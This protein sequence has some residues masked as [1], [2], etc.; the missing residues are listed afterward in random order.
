MR[1]MVSSGNLEKILAG[2]AEAS[3]LLVKN[4][5]LDESLRHLVSIMG[6]AVEADRCYV[7]KNSLLNG[8]MLMDQ[9]AEWTADG[10]SVQLHNP[11]LQQVSYNIYPEL[12]GLLEMGQAVT[13]LVADAPQPFRGL[14]QEQDILSYLFL[15]IRA[16]GVLWGF[17]GYDACLEPRQWQEY[18][19]DAL[20]TMANAFGSY[21]EN[22]A[23]RSALEISN[24]RYQLAIEG[25]KDGIWE[26]DLRTNQSFLSDLWF[27]TFG[28]N[29][30]D[31]TWSYDH[32]L[33]L[34]HP[35]DRQ[36]VDDGF[37]HFLQ[38]GHGTNDLEFRFLHGRGHYV[39]VQS[40]SAAEWDENGNPLRMA[41]S[42]S[43][44]TSRKINEQ[45]LAEN[46][47]QYRQLVN[48][49]K[50]VVFEAD[51]DGKFTFINQSWEKFTGYSVKETLGQ[52]AI[53]F[54]HPSELPHIA[55]MR[56][57]LDRNPN[58]YLTYE[59][60]YQHKNGHQVWA[61]VTIK[62][63]LG[64]TGM[65]LGSAG[66]IIDLTPRR[67]AEKQ[68]QLSEAKYR[69]ISENITDI[70]TQHDT[71]GLI[72][73]A[74]PSMREVLGY[75]PNDIIGL[76]PIDYIHPADRDHVINNAFQKLLHGERRINIA[77]RV[78]HKAGH[79]VWVESL[80]RFIPDTMGQVKAIQASTRDISER[81]KSE[82]EVARALE[83]EKELMELRSRFV[84]MASHEF[85]TPLA[86][87]RSSLDILR[88]YLNQADEQLQAKSF[89]HF[90][91]MQLEIERLGELMN[92]ILLL[93]KL[94][95]GKTSLQLQPTNLPDLVKNLVEM[96]YSNPE[97]GRIPKIYVEGTTRP[98]LLDQQLINHCLMNLIS[99]ALK[100]SEGAEAPHITVTHKRH[101]VSISVKDFGI[102][103]K[104]SDK[105]RL[106][107]PFYR[108]NNVG[109][110]P[111]SGLGL[112][113]VKEFVQLHGGKVYCS[114][115][116]GKGTTFNMDLFG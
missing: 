100:F 45:I 9:Q 79:Y 24:Q 26:L 10:I 20:Q 18:E 78:K 35:D 115:S 84:M 38:R 47:R 80:T 99:N 106:F 54:V 74:S 21:L 64:P 83:K 32:W 69:L 16:N 91:K 102:G 11:E 14:M 96:H 72:T 46:E 56:E 39:W 66:T 97:D 41:G 42:D 62:R 2:V 60:K 92:E 29:R 59:I 17:I 73:F 58:D 75:D 3:V 70:V 55:R 116:P 52:A 77:Y 53:N 114:S 40:K 108:G 95:A 33:S 61:E 82:E 13:G 94:E 112:V 88:I 101:H 85:R 93:G 34:V 27:E 25:S 86:T 22:R 28:H 1:T 44:I 63:V 8:E 51:A 12:L 48:N 5:D 89:K 87:I 37:T 103:I 67:L 105:K 31:G 68:L 109:K 36:F 4:L 107:E 76:Q 23:L 113:V 110:I 43:D 98:V 15:P 49:L 50:E 57:E 6:K 90:D 19:S 71:T 7:F 81:K 65:I 30:K 111:G 104:S